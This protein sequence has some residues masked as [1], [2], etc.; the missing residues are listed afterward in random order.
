MATPELAI[1]EVEKEMRRFARVVSGMNTDL[2][3]LLSTT[4]DE[5][6]VALVAKL[7]QSEESTDRFKKAISTYLTELAKLEV[8]QDTSIKLRGL[9]GGVNN[10]ER[11]GDL[12][13]QMS[14][15]L[16]VKNEQK[17][18]FIPKQRQSLKEMA[19]LVGRAFDVM[20]AN[21]KLEDE[22]VDLAEARQLEQE[23]NAMRDELREKHLQDMSKDRYTQSSGI[24]YSDTFS[25]LEEIADQIFGVTEGLG[26]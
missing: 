22:S 26:K 5:E 15:S 25:A 17:V 20:N 23:V 1:L 2:I 19:L 12:Y 10:L 7:R 6:R 9:M 13:Y 18:Y 16:Q 4:D 11:I 24:F 14:L 21:L 8:A 3:K